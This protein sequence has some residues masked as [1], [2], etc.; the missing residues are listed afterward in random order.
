MPARHFDI[1]FLA[2]PRFPGGTSTALATEIQAAGRAGL[3]IALK[4]VRSLLL[5]NHR[6]SHPQILAEL[7]AAG[8]TLLGPEDRAEA[9]FAVLH[10]PMVFDSYPRT[11]LGVRADHVILVLHHPPRDGDGLSEYD[12]RIIGDT[13]KTLMGKRPVLAPVG[14]LVRA[15]LTA[16]NEAVLDEDWHNL[17]DVDDLPDLT[18]QKPPEGRFRIGRHSRPLPKKWPADL[19]TARRVYPDI[20]WL[21]VSMLGADKAKLEQKYG[22]LPKHW[23]LLPFAHGVT[24]DYLSTLDAWVYYHDPQWVE[25]FGRAI[26]EAAGSGLP[27]I[28]PRHFEPLFGPACLYAAEDEVADVIKELRENPNARRLQARRARKEIRRRFGLQAFVGRLET[29]DPDWAQLRGG[30][31]PAAPVK[32]RRAQGL[33]RVMYISSNGVGLGHLTRLLAVAEADP[34]APLPVFFTL[35]RGAGF[36]R[37]AGFPCEYTPFH[38]GL[39]VD[40][41]AWNASLTQTL[42]E[43]ADF[44]GIGTIVF[45]GNVPYQGLLDFL[46]MRRDVRSAWMRRGFWREGHAQALQ[47]AQY[48]DLLLSPKDFAQVL[49][50]G[51]TAA[52]LGETSAE[53]PPVWRRVPGPT[54]DRD[55]AL[56]DLGLDPSPGHVLVSLGSL[57]NFDLAGLPELILKGI[58]AQGRVPVVL[59]S[60]LQQDSPGKKK[61]AHPEGTVERAV[62]PVERHLAAFD[63]AVSAAGYNSFHEFTANGLPTLWVPNEAGEMDQQEKRAQFARLT[64]TGDCLR[65]SEEMK[66][67]AVLQRFDS[68]AARREMRSRCTAMQPENGAR[69]A[70]EAIHALSAMTAMRDR[71]PDPKRATAP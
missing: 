56:A 63:Y 42:L 9:R 32:R 10:H 1:V 8:A 39:D 65:A 28:L 52:G 13:V 43:A 25:A 11:A 68:D 35:S 7:D 45:D 44:H 30:V 53:L 4:P 40:L 34:T 5:G 60:P 67:L 15:Q 2:D 64:G 70:A 47:R 38:R 66:A 29:L 57:T 12:V 18:G 16:C 54:L 59:S 50:D 19:A 26:L 46:E 61:P 37:A 33:S 51:P 55:G 14:P 24:N 21:D 17:I 31:T 41:R 69:A 48:F 58:L 3:T 49:D 62:Y 22:V 23:R 6:L 71:A 20:P 27:T 36:V